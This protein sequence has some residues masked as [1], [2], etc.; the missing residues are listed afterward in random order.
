MHIRPISPKSIVKA[1]SLALAGLLACCVAHAA[2][3]RQ[4]TLCSLAI[5]HVNVVPMD[6]ERV[7]E[8]R[9]VLI[10]G[11]KILAIE[12]AAGAPVAKCRQIIDGAG[13]YLLPGLNDLHMHIETTAFEQ[14]FG[15]KPDPIDYPS[16][17]ALYIANGVTGLR[18]M[19][20]APDILAFRNSQRGTASPYPRLVVASPM[21]SGDPPVLPEPV[22]KVLK[23]PAEAREAVRSYARAGYDF[24]K[25]RDN[26][27]VPVFR[28]VIEAARREGL[29]VD[30]HIS[31]HQGLSVFDVLRSGQHA[32]A[33]IDD[34]ALQMTDKAH[35]P[36]RFVELFRDCGCFIESTIGV[37]RN[38]MEQLENY[39][40]MIARPQMRFIHPLLLNPFWLKP[41]N[42]YL[43]EKPPLDFL[44]ALYADSK[45]L[46]KKFTDAGIH[47]VSGS[48]S[49]NPMIIPGVSLHDEFDS[50]IEAGLSPY[51]A[52]KTSTANAAAYV[53]GFVDTGVLEVGRAANVVLVK[54]NPLNDV[55]ALR[56]PDAVMINGHWRERDEIERM[57]NAVAAGYGRK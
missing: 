27:K 53:P 46:L 48:D 45:M 41:N 15:A 25:V 17:L 36:D 54:T 11:G 39:D 12:R 49:L 52:L 42:P 23:T 55:R 47:V 34:L 7:L 29:Y 56:D 5:T 30:G 51:Q 10:G 3:E 1:P 20:G 31:Q 37:E 16:V 28:A 50:M 57:L 2:P 33:H 22:T 43:K 24:I 13:R 32:F 18:V 9:S 44:R 8:D 21:L 6:A 38:T 35:D 4:S 40:A 26:L 14:A 19:S